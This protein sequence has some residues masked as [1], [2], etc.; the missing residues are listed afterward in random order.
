MWTNPQIKIHKNSY[1]L[2]PIRQQ[3][4]HKSPDHMYLKFLTPLTQYVEKIVN[5]LQG[6]K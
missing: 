1:E 4:H 3:I 5:L 6:F 2:T